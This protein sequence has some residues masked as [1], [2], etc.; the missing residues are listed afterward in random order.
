MK[1]L[2]KL[3]SV[4]FWITLWAVLLITYIVLAEESEFILIAELLCAVPLA[5]LGLNVWQKKIMTDAEKKDFE[6]DS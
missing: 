6:A 5:Y 4:K 3:F 1:F 2:Q